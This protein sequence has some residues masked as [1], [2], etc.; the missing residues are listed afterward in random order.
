T[1]RR[2][3]MSYHQ[4]AA[5][6][7]DELRLAAPPVA[8]AFVAEA[9]EGVAAA[10]DRIP[11][12]CAMWRLAEQGVF[13]A[14]P[15][16]HFNCPVGATVLGLELPQALQEELMALVGTMASVGYF[17]PAEAAQLPAVRRPKRGAL[18]GPLA[19]M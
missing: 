17:D 19:E 5:T 2:T 8:I 12:S 9:P 15:E 16:S 4:I 1:E 14:P 3:P 10:G 13:Y 6:I 7:R 11:S 18:Y